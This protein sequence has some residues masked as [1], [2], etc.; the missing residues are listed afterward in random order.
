MGHVLMDRGGLQA[1]CSESQQCKM[2]SAA[3]ETAWTDTKDNLVDKCSSQSLDLAALQ[4]QYVEERPALKAMPPQ[5]LSQKWHDNAHVPHHYQQPSHQTPLNSL[6]R[7]LGQCARLAD[8]DNF[9]YAPRPIPSPHSPSTH[10]I[11]PLNQLNLSTRSWDLQ[12]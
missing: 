6:E 5:Q 8:R 4:V 10:L 9:D 3:S 11:P 2:K 7:I 1:Q 12:N